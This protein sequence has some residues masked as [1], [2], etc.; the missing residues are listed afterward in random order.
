MRKLDPTLLS[1]YDYYLPKSLIA[2]HPIKPKEDAGLLVY[3]RDD[4]S[5]FHAK[6]GELFEFLPKNLSVLL[7][8]T[9]VVKAR[10]FG[11]KQSGGGVELLF[12]SMV[13]EHEFKVYIK[14]RVKVGS[15]LIFDDGL[16]A[17]VLSLCDDGARVV[18]FFKDEKL[19][20]LGGLFEILNKIGHV[21]LP[22]YIK[23][24]D[25]AEDEEDY[26]TL[27]A[28]NEG[29]VAA[30]TASL[31]FSDESF[32]KLKERFKTEFITLHVGAGTFKGVESENIREHAMHS[33]YF[34]IPDNAAKIIQSDEAILSVG[35]TVTRSVEYFARTQKTQG[36]CNLFLNPLNP[37]IRVN[38]LLTN[39]HLPKSTLIMLVAGFVGVDETLRIYKEAVDKKYRFFSYGD[40]MLIL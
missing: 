20:C 25:T 9:K 28:K 3:K 26:Q 22:P 12:N 19:L 24:E 17:V 11:F 1:S 34:I 32:L 36:E 13:K 23:R 6:F 29:A 38:H 14:G 35:T 31:H 30:P 37:P 15:K 10:I 18:N 33:E 27:F 7:N 2:S 40:A 21:P 8:D 4:K 5:I 16:S 39:F